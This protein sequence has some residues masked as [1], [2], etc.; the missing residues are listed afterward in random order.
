MS[1]SS[2]LHEAIKLPMPS[3][4]SY[5][6]Y[7]LG[8]TYRATKT[9]IDHAAEVLGSGV[10]ACSLCSDLIRAGDPANKGVELVRAGC[11]C[12]AIYHG[13]CW[14]RYLSEPQP[15]TKVYKNACPAC[16]AELYREEK[17]PREERRR[18]ERL[19]RQESSRLEKQESSR[20]ERKESSGSLRGTFKVLFRR[21]SSS[22]SVKSLPRTPR[23]ATPTSRPSSPGDKPLPRTPTSSTQDSGSTVTK[24]IAGM[25][26]EDRVRVALKSPASKYDPVKTIA[27]ACK[28][29]HFPSE[30]ASAM[31]ANIYRLIYSL[32]G[33]EVQISTLGEWIVG[34]ARSALAKFVASGDMT[35]AEFDRAMLPGVGVVSRVQA[36]VLFS[37]T[38][39]EA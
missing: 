2:S 36:L 21:G 34:A 22:G 19:E 8:D 38:N 33:Q 12:P 31:T 17:I 13:E 28:L 27:D 26:G 29:R 15:G 9:D 37:L 39:D 3:R 23:A 1:S 4:R 24:G 6:G 25:N 5:L 7:R 16:D 32:E 30:Y 20:L 18:R 35:G 11:Q 10:C 14:R